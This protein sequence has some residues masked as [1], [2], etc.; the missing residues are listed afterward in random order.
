MGVSEAD[1]SDT[2][3]LIAMCGGR[4]SES[5]STDPSEDLLE[6]NEP[7]LTSSCSSVL[8]PLNRPRKGL[9]RTG[10]C[11]ISGVSPLS[12]PLI[13]PLSEFVPDPFPL[14]RAAAVC[15]VD[16]ISANPEPWIDSTVLRRVESEMSVPRSN[17]I[18]FGVR[19]RSPS[20]R[21]PNLP[22][23]ARWTMAFPVSA[24]PV[25]AALVSTAPVSDVP[26]SAPTFS[27]AIVSAAPGV[28]AA[29]PVSAAPVSATAF[30]A[31]G[32]GAPMSSD[33]EPTGLL[34]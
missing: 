13:D 8:A 16:S 12:E 32:S 28:A 15:E 33:T 21:L 26:V 17:S 30:G 23:A 9:W 20:L 25:S 14:L 27:A 29:A 11:A 24:D 3:L 18:A 1:A 10:T 5:T 22:I 34:K 19:R 6:Y 7:R 4:K 2:F 31:R